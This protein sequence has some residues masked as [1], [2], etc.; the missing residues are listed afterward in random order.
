VAVKCGRD[1]R[2]CVEPVSRAAAFFE[3]RNHRLGRP[4]PLSKSTLAES[5]SRSKIVNQLAWAHWYGRTLLAIVFLTRGR[6]M[7]M[8]DVRLA[9]V[10]G[11]VAG[12]YGP[13]RAAVGLFLGFAVGS[14]FVRR[15][16]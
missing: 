11:A 9:L 8:G 5:R 13:D 14:V 10:L 4:H 15:E 3:P 12:W 1:S 6:G 7:G 16:R 2:Q